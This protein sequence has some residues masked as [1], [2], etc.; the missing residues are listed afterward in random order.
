MKKSYSSKD[1]YL[2]TRTGTG[3]V[4]CFGP[5]LSPT[6]SLLA[7]AIG[8]KVSLSTELPALSPTHDFQG[9]PWLIHG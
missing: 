7:S 6:F 4:G 3:A 1:V 2:E 9:M 5:Q 8:C